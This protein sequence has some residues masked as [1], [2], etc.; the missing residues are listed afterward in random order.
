MMMRKITT[1]NTMMILTDDLGHSV[2]SVL[3]VK[4]HLFS[5]VVLAKGTA[6]TI[7]FLAK[8]WRSPLFILNT[9]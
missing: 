1:M 2:I 5:Y 6:I 4:N 8:L 9:I 7:D 3:F